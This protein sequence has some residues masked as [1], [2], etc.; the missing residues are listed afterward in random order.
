MSGGKKKNKTDM[1]D[2]AGAQPNHLYIW[3]PRQQENKDAGIGGRALIYKAYC[4][5][6]SGLAKKKQCVSY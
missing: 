2:G 5:D 1:N 3:R 6:A 4:F